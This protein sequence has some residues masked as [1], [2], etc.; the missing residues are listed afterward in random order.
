[1]VGFGWFEGE[2]D[3]GAARMPA[4]KPTAVW[5]GAG[6]TGLVIPTGGADVDCLARSDGELTAGMFGEPL[7]VALPV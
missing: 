5:A 3:S 2:L 6:L 4:C 7:R 1:M